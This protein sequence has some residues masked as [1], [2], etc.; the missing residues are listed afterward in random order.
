[1]IFFFFNLKR[2]IFRYNLYFINSI[3]SEIAPPPPPPPSPPPPPYPTLVP[4]GL[5]TVACWPGAASFIV[6]GCGALATATLPSNVADLCGAYT[7]RPG[8]PAPGGVPQLVNGAGVTLTFVPN[9]TLAA[10]LADD[11]GFGYSTTQQLLYRHADVFVFA[12]AALTLRAPTAGVMQLN[13]TAAG[14]T[15]VGA[16]GSYHSNPLAADVDSSNW[17]AALDTAQFIYSYIA[18]VQQPECL[19]PSSPCLQRT[20]YT[21]MAVPLQISVAC[22]ALPPPPSPPPPSPPP[23]IPPGGVVVATA[24]ITANLSLTG[25]SFI[26]AFGA[27]DRDAVLAA[28]AAAVRH[29]SCFAVEGKAFC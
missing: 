25:E 19:S 26:A 28:V 3:K 27:A 23:P 11:T 20:M 8:G 24:T 12:G 6:A 18:E 29:R 5:V 14:G 7:S 16:P 15:A 10:D 9:A 17:E 2:R 22:A 1:V 13:A 4:P 21:L